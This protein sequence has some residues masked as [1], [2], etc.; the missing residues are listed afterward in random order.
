MLDLIV[1]LRVVD[2]LGNCAVLGLFDP[3]LPGEVCVKRGEQ[4]GMRRQ[5]VPDESDRQVGH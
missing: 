3:L 5:E 4:I 2:E 1:A